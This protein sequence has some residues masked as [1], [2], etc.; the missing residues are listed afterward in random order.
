MEWIE[1]ADVVQLVL[2]ELDK[3]VVKHLGVKSIRD[4]IRQ[5]SDVILSRSFVSW[6]MHLHDPD[7]FSGRNPTAKR[8]YRS[9]KYPIGINH[10]WSS[11]GHDKLYS[12]GYPIYAIVDDATGKT[13]GAWVLP[14]NRQQ[15]IILYVYLCCVEKY[16]GIPLTTTTDCGTETLKM[17]NMQKELRNTFHP[18]I[19]E[20][21]VP[22]HI[23]LRSVHNI[24]VER[25]WYRL[26]LDFGDRAVYLFKEGAIQGIYNPHDAD[27]VQLSLW[28]WSWIL[29][30]ELDATV[31][32]RNNSAVRKQKAKPGPS[33]FSRNIAY[34]LYEQWGGVDCK[35]VVDMNLIREQKA[36]L[37]GDTLLEFTTLEFSQRAQAV[38]VTL[39]EVPLSMESGWTLFQVMLPDV[40][41]ERNFLRPVL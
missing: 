5:T 36:L 39:G 25:S 16:S 29:Q 14:S 32:F 27:H 31:E 10:K 1:H 7:G 8:I 4:K 17:V 6:M 28:L 30:K 2:D 37:G 20:A 35:L 24:S 19:S 23:Y 38:F 9:P 11:D 34:T 18:D 41:P 40:F 12:I 26:R 22:A 21:E 15:D 33:G 13:L 3:D